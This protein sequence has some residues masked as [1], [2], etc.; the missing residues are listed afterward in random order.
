MVSELSRDSDLRAVQR[1]RELMR[2]HDECHGNRGRRSTA[3]GRVRMPNTRRVFAAVMGVCLFAGGCTTAT[4]AEAPKPVRPASTSEPSLALDLTPG[5][6]ANNVAPG[7]PI[8]VDAEYGELT[9]VTL[10]GAD[11]TVV[12][13]SLNDDSTAWRAGE[14]LGFGKTYTLTA[15]GV[16]DD[17]ERVVERSR[18]TTATPAQ[19]VSVWPA[20]VDGATVGV[21]MPVSL[22]FSA[23][24]KNKDAAERALRVTSKP[25]TK[26]AFHWFSDEWVV[27][28]PKEHWKPRTKV[29]IDAEVYGRHFGNGVYGAQDVSTDMKIG[30]RVVAVAN[31]KTHRMNVW[32][33]GNK[34]KRM[35]ISMGK[36]T[37]PTPHGTYTVMSEHHDYTMDSSTYGV[38][39]NADEGYKITVTHA[40]RLSYSG[41][42]YHSAPWS[43]GDQGHRNVSHGCINL[44][45]P[46]AA[47]MMNH[48]KPGDLF[49]VTKSGGQRLEPTD[50]FSVWQ[51]PWRKWRTGGVH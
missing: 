4:H 13:G 23:P 34:V 26:G 43:V 28:R 40:T 31:G 39:V 33:N 51:M 17:G 41:I 44:S 25:Q 46:D 12:K 36:P 3:S 15:R 9:K 48:S 24:I 11:G 38:P 30:K 29:S 27:W 50:G 8:T 14:K 32:I 21:G 20:V 18:F 22:Q 1:A 2:R 47:W 19:T 6:K 42:F 49:R 35:P 7:K 45:A 10:I 37:H 16:G 5:P